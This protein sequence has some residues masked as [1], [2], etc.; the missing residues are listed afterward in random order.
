MKLVSGSN[1]SVVV[2]QCTTYLGDTICF[3]MRGALIVLEGCDRAGKS[4][5]SR[6][7]LEKIRSTG[8]KAELL[9]FPGE[10]ACFPLRSLSAAACQAVK[11]KFKFHGEVI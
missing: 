2:G 7:L 4:V 3:E 6:K 9:V 11:L 1:C 8:A 10:Y 5:Q